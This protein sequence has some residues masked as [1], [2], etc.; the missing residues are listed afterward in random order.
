ME[1]WSWAEVLDA[2]KGLVYLNSAPHSGTCSLAAVPVCPRYMGLWYDKEPQ[3]IICWDKPLCPRSSEGRSRYCAGGCYSVSWVVSEVTR[4]SP[5]ESRALT[6]VVLKREE[7]SLVLVPCSIYSSE[8]H[9]CRSLE[10]ETRWTLTNTLSGFF[11][12]VQSFVFFLQ[13]GYSIAIKETKVT[14]LYT[15][16]GII[17]LKKIKSTISLESVY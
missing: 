5:F 14:C 6:W 4:L 7:R 8:S 10:K 13:W 12:G 16:T 3:L 9:F 2:V 15:I 17:F 11:W 1:R